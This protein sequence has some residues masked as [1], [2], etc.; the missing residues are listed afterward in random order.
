[1]TV[2]TKDFATW[3]EG[4]QDVIRSPLNPMIVSFSVSQECKKRTNQDVKL[5]K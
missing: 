3:R 4:V 2:S 5:R 1:M